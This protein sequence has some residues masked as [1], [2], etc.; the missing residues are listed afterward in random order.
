M[1]MYFQV[2]RQLAKACS[3][4]LPVLYF[5]DEMDVINRDQ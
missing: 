3:E 4:W 1:K 2:L 5:H